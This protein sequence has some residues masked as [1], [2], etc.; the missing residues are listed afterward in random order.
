MED[1]NPETGKPERIP[2]SGAFAN[3]KVNAP[4]TED[5]YWDVKVKG[6]K[7]LWIYQGKKW[8]GEYSINEMHFDDAALALFKQG[9]AGRPMEIRLKIQGQGGER[10]QTYRLLHHDA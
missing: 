4:E 7:P 5:A 1:I 10:F 9:S 3:E 8:V 2:M 6:E